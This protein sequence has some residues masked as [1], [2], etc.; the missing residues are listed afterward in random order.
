M[1][2]MFQAIKRIVDEYDDLKIVY[3][4]HMN[5][6]VRDTAKE[7]FGNNDRVRLIEPLE[8]V[9][10]HNFISRS[11]IIL[12]DSGGIQEE[13]PSLGKP[14]LVLRD[15]TERPE[16]IAAGTLKLAGTEEETIYQLMKELLD[17]ETVY[18]A[19]S[20]ASNPYGDGHASERIAD[21]IEH[22]E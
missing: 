21:A 16:G 12:T 8:V 19:M 17:D 20:H 1:K 10:F 18:H 3:P 11:H 5:P 22:L 7:V 9:D 6:L 4:I 2:Q 14:V 15:T 13:A